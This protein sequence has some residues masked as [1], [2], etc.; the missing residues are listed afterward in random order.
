MFATARIWC[1]RPQSSGYRW[2]NHRGVARL[3]IGR[4]LD[5]GKAVGSLGRLSTIAGKAGEINQGCYVQ[6]A[7]HDFDGDDIPE[8]VVAV[9]DGMLDMALN[10][11]T[12][13]APQSPDKAVRR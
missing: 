9:G 2:H 7:E 6:V 4:P 1:Q 10:V 3:G 8:I 11:V 5:R 13:Y 12:Y